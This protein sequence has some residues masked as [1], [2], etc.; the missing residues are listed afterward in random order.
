MRNFRKFSVFRYC[1]NSLSARIFAAANQ[2][3]KI[4]DIFGKGVTSLKQNSYLLIQSQRYLTMFPFLYL[5]SLSVMLL[6]LIY[7]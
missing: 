2:I 3:R 1:K 5:S 6:A 7:N 4:V